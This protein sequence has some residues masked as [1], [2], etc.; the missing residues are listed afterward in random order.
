MGHKI[1]LIIGD[2]TAQIGDA[3]D[4]QAMRK[5]L[6]EKEI[7]EKFKINLEEEVMYVGGESNG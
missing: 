7:K 6:T 2:F 3:S 4:K 1:V 5:V